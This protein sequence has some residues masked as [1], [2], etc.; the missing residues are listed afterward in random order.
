MVG[1]S[2][3]DMA[4]MGEHGAVADVARAGAADFAADLAA[5]LTAVVAADYA[6]T[7]HDTHSAHQE[8][9]WGPC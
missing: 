4:R 7:G 6:G 1:S 3:A 9:P 5:D 2:N 8:D